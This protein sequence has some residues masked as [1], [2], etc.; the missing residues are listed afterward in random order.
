MIEDDE[1]SFS[2]FISWSRSEAEGIAKA[3]EAMIDRVFEGRKVRALIFGPD[4]LGDMWI[5]R[6]TKELKST[7]AV[8]ACITERNYLSP[9]MAYEVGAC[10]G[11]ENGQAYSLLCNMDKGRL[12]GPLQHLN[13]ISGNR[14]GI[15]RLFVRL[16]QNIKQDSSKFNKAF[17]VECPKLLEFVRAVPSEENRW[18]VTLDDAQH[19]IG[20]WIPEGGKRI[21]TWTIMESKELSEAT[22]KTETH[23]NVDSLG[24]CFGDVPEGGHRYVL[25]RGPLGLGKSVLLYRH[26]LSTNRCCLI[27]MNRLLDDDSLSYDTILRRVRISLEASIAFR[28][29]EDPAP[30]RPCIIVDGL[31]GAAR[32][33]AIRTG[34]D[35]RRIF[36]M[37]IPALHSEIRRLR[38]DRAL[39]L[40]SG[41]DRSDGQ[42]HDT[43][44]ELKSELE[45]L[46]RSESSV[47]TRW[48]K[49]S[50]NERADWQLLLS[51]AMERGRD[52]THQ[53]LAIFLDAYKAG[54][55]SRSIL[56]L[57][58]QRG[59]SYPRALDK[60]ARRIP[61]RHVLYE[62]AEGIRIWTE[63]V[64]KLDSSRG[65]TVAR[66]I[67][68]VKDEQTWEWLYLLKLRDHSDVVDKVW[69]LHDFLKK[70]SFRHT[71]A[72][73]N[74][75][76][77]LT[78]W[79]EYGK[80]VERQKYFHCN[81]RR[82]LLDTKIVDAE[83]YYT[84][85]TEAQLEANLD[86]ENAAFVSCL[87]D[88][89]T[90]AELISRFGSARCHIS[91]PQ[92][93]E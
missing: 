49:I 82:V 71:A 88:S 45:R 10:Y 57:L 87:L 79:G 42:E 26:F 63:K 29:E 54:D 76:S 34:V 4:V 58:I 64:K 18:T 67:T 25:L 2:I 27:D 75:I 73:S 3:L 78:N 17:N 28:G 83:F 84:D 11:K 55:G 23:V 37:V 69:Q 80:Y 56:D 86:F 85:L 47:T 52:T 62:V 90:R 35:E 39:V 16:N 1:P 50:E 32:R 9:W 44:N 46:P 36:R 72:L 43:V 41:D 51:D 14:D 7:Y 60:V 89:K 77:L 68:D 22:P 30:S 19:W 31:D 15:K 5:Y 53:E 38:T 74:I 40:I 6:L 8:I 48:L 70:S 91:E 93:D 65:E 21:E 59:S 61:E 66:C 24:S 92:N 81:L 12:E 33:V 20:S 13:H